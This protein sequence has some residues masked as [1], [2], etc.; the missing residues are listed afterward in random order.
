LKL[1]LINKLFDNVAKRR[2]LLSQ[3]PFF[4]VYCVSEIYI[5]LVFS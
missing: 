2:C 5:Q 4:K 1:L 3:F